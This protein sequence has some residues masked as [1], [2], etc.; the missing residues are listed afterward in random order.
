MAMYKNNFEPRSNIDISETYWGVGPGAEF[1]AGLPD[2]ASGRPKDGYTWGYDSATGDLYFKA[3]YAGGSPGQEAVRFTRDAQT[4][5]IKSRTDY[6][7]ELRHNNTADRQYDF[8]DASGPVVVLN[9]TQQVGGGATA[10]LGTIGGSG[11]GTEFQSIWG[12]L[13]L[14]GTTYYV[15]LW[16]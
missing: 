7:G 12:E 8:P 13:V 1:G 4:I 2:L 14:N 9:A 5:K 3:R 11:P 6:W 10:V 16:R 15:P